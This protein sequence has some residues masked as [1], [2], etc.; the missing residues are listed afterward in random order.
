MPTKLNIT[1]ETLELEY[2]ENK[3]SS[4]EIAAM[5]GCNYM[6]ILNK[7]KEFGIPARKDGQRYGHITKELLEK[8]YIENGLGS[9]V[10]AKKY[11]CSQTQI[12]RRLKKFGILTRSKD[13]LDNLEHRTFDEWTVLS[14]TEKGYLCR[15]SCGKEYDIGRAN[16]ISGKSSCCKYCSRSKRALGKHPG[17]KGYEGISGTQWHRVRASAKKRAVDLDI[18]IEYIWE[19]YLKQDRKCVLTGLPISMGVSANSFMNG[20]Y[21]ASLDRI[22]SSKGYVEGNVQWVHKD[23]NQIKSNLS[24]DRFIELCKL[25]AKNFED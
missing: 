11:G 17:W 10:L 21:S 23:I 15:C 16:L 7:M 5:F 14:R 13:V 22:D 1:K 20:D 25:V 9:T 12:I 24:Q 2:L 18:T 19:T 4:T 8:D 6:T 3:K